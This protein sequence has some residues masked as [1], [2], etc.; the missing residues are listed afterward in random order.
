MQPHGPEPPAQR[1]LPAA[2]GKILGLLALEPLP[3]SGPSA[4]RRRKNFGAFDH[5]C[6]KNDHFLFAN[7]LLPLRRTLKHCKE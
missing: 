7:D 1:F 3:R 5:F 4:R 6:L 2:G